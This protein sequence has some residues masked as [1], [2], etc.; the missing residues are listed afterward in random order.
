L[1]GLEQ[2]VYRV[3]LYA[4]ASDGIGPNKPSGSDRIFS[5]GSVWIGPPEFIDFSRR[6]ARPVDRFKLISQL[7][8]TARCDSVAHVTLW[9]NFPT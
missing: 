6:S 7:I 9:D 5:V 4:K 2:S 8:K 3:I 1:D